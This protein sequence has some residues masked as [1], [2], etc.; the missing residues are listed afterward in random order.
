MKLKGIE[1][2]YVTSAHMFKFLNF[3]LDNKTV[4][5]IMNGYINECIK[6]VFPGDIKD[7]MWSTQ[8]KEQKD[9]KNNS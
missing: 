7:F 2:I 5:P 1:D 3:K 4:L 6:R 8:Q 9:K